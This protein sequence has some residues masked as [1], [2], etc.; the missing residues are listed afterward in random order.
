[1]AQ[2]PTI[3]T[4]EITSQVV[5]T[6]SE[7]KRN[8]M[9]HGGLVALLILHLSAFTIY[10]I[11]R[12][13]QNLLVLMALLTYIMSII[14]MSGAA[15]INGFIFPNFLQDIAVNNQHLLELSPLINTYSWNFNQTLSSASVVATSCA[16]TL[17]SLNLFHSNLRQ[18]LLAVIGLGI[19]VAIAILMLGG[20]LALDLIGM[21]SVVIAQ[22]LWNMGLAY[23][24][25][26]KS[27][28]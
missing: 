1:M 21:T 4:T 20:W 17:W 26:S 3:N 25:I 15:L 13:L 7:M 6:V 11:S 23:L 18:N 8:K 10:S 2:H 28:N 16:I 19:G 14:M 27:I 12:G 22:S 24:L 9:V 5:E